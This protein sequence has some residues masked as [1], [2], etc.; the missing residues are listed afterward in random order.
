[1]N[2]PAIDE[3]KIDELIAMCKNRMNLSYYKYGSVRH[4]IA[5]GRCDPI[6]CIDL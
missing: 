3:K 2:D 1:M 4:N 5:G 6:G